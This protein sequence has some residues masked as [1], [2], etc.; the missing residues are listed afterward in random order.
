[1]KRFLLLLIF[2]IAII[3]YTYGQGDVVIYKSPETVDPHDYSEIKGS[4]YMFD[5]WVIGTLMGKTGELIAD[6]LIN[7]NAY[8][9]RFESKKD[10]QL[11]ELDSKLY[12][13]AEIL[14]EKNPELKLERKIILQKGSHYDINGFAQLMYFGEGIMLI[15]K[16]SVTLTTNKIQNV[17]KTIEVKRF[18]K[19]RTYY[20]VINGQIHT[21]KLKKKDFLKVIGKNKQLEEY[22]EN[23]KLFYSKEEDIIQMLEKYEQIS[24]QDG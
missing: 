3:Q 20:L 15:K 4:P 2:P 18:G 12:I 22:V 17:G 24:N 13:R 1:M 7:Y 9:D 21:I 8:T 5:E 6:V 14:P 16:L 11:I 23:N 19:L 10:D